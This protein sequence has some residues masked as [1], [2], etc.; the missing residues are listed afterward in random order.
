[1]NSVNFNIL[2]KLFKIVFTNYDI[3]FEN[4]DRHT[5]N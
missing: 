2:C 4:N 3:I 5:Q 1:M